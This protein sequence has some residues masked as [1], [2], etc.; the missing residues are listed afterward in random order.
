MVSAVLVDAS[1]SVSARIS[2]LR[3]LAVLYFFLPLLWGCFSFPGGTS[4]AGEV[5]ISRILPSATGHL[6]VSGPYDIVLVP[7]SRIEARMPAAVAQS[8]VITQTKENT[9]IKPRRGFLLS[10]HGTVELLI[11]IDSLS[12]LEIKTTGVISSSNHL[13]KPHLS[14]TLAGTVS[15]QLSFNAGTLNL[16]CTSPR[17]I[18]LSGRVK[19]LKL[20]ATDLTHLDLRR[21]DIG[22]PDI[23]QPGYG[24]IIKL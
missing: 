11:G 2:S 1:S 13:V 6:S 17:N 10:G 15:G 3:L 22:E 4:R 16:R 23:Q 7:G 14:L 8:L 20:E 24:A 19:V 18:A 21:L 5:Q 9:I 12:S